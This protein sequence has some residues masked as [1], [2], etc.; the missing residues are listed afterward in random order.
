MFHLFGHLEKA[1]VHQRMK[2]WSLFYC[3]NTWSKIFSSEQHSSYDTVDAEECRKKKLSPACLSWISSPTSTWS[4]SASFHFSKPSALG[5]IVRSLKWISGRFKTQAARWFRLKN[6]GAFQELVIDFRRGFRK[7]AKESTVAVTKPCD[8]K[9]KLHRSCCTSTASTTQHLRLLKCDIN[10][11][12]GVLYQIGLLWKNSSATKE[13]YASV[14]EM[15]A[16][17]TGPS[18]SGT[19]QANLFQFQG[20]CILCANLTSW[21]NGTFR[22]FGE[23][24]TVWLGRQENSRTVVISS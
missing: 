6:Q 19:T 10:C 23:A 11:Y 8:L 1:L 17:I 16:E 18:Q 22:S 3:S 24:S 21:S 9:Y 13:N 4:I 12:I 20:L 14:K 7:T 5:T 2:S 15:G